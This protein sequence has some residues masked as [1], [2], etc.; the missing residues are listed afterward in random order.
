MVKVTSANFYV[1]NKQP[2]KDAKFLRSFKAHVNG[3]QEGHGGNIAAIRK[4]IGDT[5]SIRF[6][7]TFEGQ[8]VPI[9][10]PKNLKVLSFKSRQ[11]S[12]RAEV[13]NIGM[14][15]AASILRFKL[16]GEVYCFI[17]THLNAA[18]Q[19]PEGRPGNVKRVKRVFEYTQ[20]IIALEVIIKRAKKRG[21]HVILV[22]D[23]NFR[24]VPNGMGWFYSPNR[25]FKRC[26]MEF[27]S[28]RLDYVAWTR[29]LKLKSYHLIPQSKHGADHPWIVAEFDPRKS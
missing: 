1:G 11:I 29:D 17:N 20:S 5:H 19:G 8:D 12:K 3:V 24:N 7:N 10:H 25:L 6:G 14:P 4:A 23:L 28:E 16:D 21:E 18:V 9:V 27:R 15:R 22:G 2:Q 26:G 13:K